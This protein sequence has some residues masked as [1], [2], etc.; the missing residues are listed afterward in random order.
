MR[1]LALTLE[2]P[3]VTGPV[4]VHVLGSFEAWVE[5]RVEPLGGPRQQAVLARLL[6]AGDD[7]VR[8]D[9]L[10]EDVWGD[11]P[12]ATASGTLQAYVS[13]LRHALGATTVERRTGGSYRLAPELV[14]VDAR[15]FDDE[16]AEGM[17][18]LAEGDPEQA[19][20]ALERGLERWRHGPA[21]GPLCGELFLAAVVERLE[22][23]RLAGVEAL[24]DAHFV[25]ERCEEDLPV[26]LGLAPAFP[27]RESL[28][29][30]LMRAL[31]AA[32]RPADALAAYERC[33]RYLAE[34]LGV[35][36]A[37][38]L[39]KAYAAVLAQEPMAPV[40][41]LARLAGLPLRSGDGGGARR[42]RWSLP[43][44]D[45]SFAGRTNLLRAAEAVLDRPGSAPRLIALHGLGGVGKTEL[46]LE[47]AHRRHTP[48][49]ICWWIVADSAQA[50]AR[51]LADLA[52]ALDIPTTLRQ[53][54]MVA[55]LWDDLAGRQRWQLVFDNVEEPE[56][57]APFLP[58]VGDGEII[59]TS[60][61]PMWRRLGTPL[62][63]TPFER[64]ES[65]AF[66]LMRTGTGAGA[67]EQ[68]AADSVAESLGDL[69][70]ALEHACAY[71]EQTGLRLDG[72][73]RL[74][75]NRREDLLT[76]ALP[77]TD[78]GAVVA[79]W[80]LSVE[81]LRQRS[82][83][84]ARMLETAA[85]LA[86]EAIPLGLLA[87]G[88]GE[89]LS[90]NEGVAELLRLSLLDRDDVRLRV[91]RLVQTAVRV[92]LSSTARQEVLARAVTGLAAMLPPD[93]D[94]ALEMG[95]GEVTSG[96]T[97]SW[98]T[99][100]AHVLTLVDH[101]GAGADASP[102]GTALEPV[103][104]A[105]L[106]VVLPCAAWLAERALFP[107]A[108][109]ALR[110]VIG[111]TEAIGNETEQ[112]LARCAFGEVLDRSGACLDGRRELE[113]GVAQL[114]SGLGLDDVRLAHAYNRLGHVLHCAGESDSAICAHER[115]LSLLRKAG[116]GVALARV[117][118]CLGYVHWSMHTLPAAH[119]CFTESLAVLEALR[120]PVPLLAHT[121]GGLGLVEQDDGRLDEALALEQRAL[122]LFTCLN[123]P[124]HPDVAQTWDKLG[125]LLRLRGDVSGAVDAAERS[126]RDLEAVMGPRDSRVAMSLTNAGLAYAEAGRTADARAAQRRASTLFMAA[127]GAS[128]PSTLLAARRLA[129]LQA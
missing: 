58:P 115:A 68:Q 76:R 21:F 94:A 26:L 70:L 85:F 34:E 114:E 31:Y 40:D 39:Q 84:A 128:H 5:G 46:A 109:Q 82:T 80:Q 55:A 11:N 92:Q 33:R 105:L 50:I 9:Q 81:R 54:E 41:R 119:A 27:L 117:L 110:L 116:G 91:H 35:D 37:P 88:H 63:V 118:T 29:L 23:R 64:N 10:V 66:V 71:I 65:R 14:H 7:G 77:G 28:V 121:L 19:A 62:A 106:D 129:A 8:A 4:E 67:A 126:I 107:A 32:G 25:L 12:P 90:A 125:Y 113:R 20:R 56:H 60:R 22:D 101:I 51:G 75:R 127:Y 102:R 74:L 43:A 100:A 47:L 45:R 103:L 72:Y 15:A 30:R 111:L 98:D 89:E 122:A 112:G 53:E 83:Y 97:E 99:L 59:V 48:E 17:R 61:N 44:R 57:L 52:K 87:A 16:V 49:R 6:I 18:A 69:P 79:T 1:Q 93:P 108:L 36:P 120:D 42:G 96:T 123:G 13:R 38:G 73:A 86:P 3:S 95:G 2:R 78:G 24:A 104:P 124:R